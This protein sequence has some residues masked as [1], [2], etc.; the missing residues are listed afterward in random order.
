VS[1]GSARGTAPPTTYSALSSPTTEAVDTA[2]AAPATPGVYADVT[3]PVATAAGNGHLP[4]PVSG[5]VPA[6]RPPGWM[7]RRRARARK[8]R[9]TVRHIDPWSVFK[10]SVLL[11]LCLY[12]AVLLAGVLLWS[13]AVGSGLIDNVESFIEELLAFETYEFQADEIFRGFAIIGLVLAAAGAAFNVVMAIVFNLIS[14]LTG[15]LR[16]TVLEEDEAIPYVQAPVASVPV[17]AP[18]PVQ[19]PVQAPPYIP[20][21]PAPPRAPRHAAPPSSVN[22]ASGPSGPAPSSVPPDRVPARRPASDPPT[23][24]NPVVSPSV[25][26]GSS[27]V[28]RQRR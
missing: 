11:Y 23:A 9:R 27:P 22:G 14:D 15:G 3:A 21:P 4:A 8:V 6:P 1:G 2:D 7:A 25:V 20:P 28:P 12:V 26:S 19:S 18:A 5:R 16:I 13:A 17:A 10:I 24:P